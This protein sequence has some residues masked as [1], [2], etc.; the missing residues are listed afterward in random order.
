MTMRRAILL[1]LA[2]SILGILG[3]V[4]AARAQ[5]GGGR[6]A[7]VVRFP[8]GSVE[9]RCV[10]F[11]GSSITGAEL[12]A[13]SGLQIILDYNSGLGGAVCSIAGSG[14][15]FPAQECFCQC[16]GLSCEYWAYYHWRAGGWE[17][18]QVGASSFAVSDGAVEGWSWG[19]GNWFSG[20]EPP[21]LAFDQVC[22][23]PTSTPTATATPAPTATPTMTSAPVRTSAPQVTFRAATT[24]LATGAC[25]LL[26][27]LVWDADRVT[28]DGAPVNGQDR[29]EVCPTTTH[30]YV[31]VAINA[32]G[33]AQ[34]EITVQVAGSQPAQE[35]PPTPAA[36]IPISA[37]PSVPEP[38]ATSA[39]DTPDHSS[40]SILVPVVRALDQPAQPVETPFVRATQPPRSAIAP[41]FLGPLPTAT[42]RPRRVLGAGGRPTPTP[43]L[44]AMA[45]AR[46]RAGVA[47][48]AQ[49]SSTAQGASQSGPAAISRE[50]TP[51]LL[52]GYA[53][54]LVMAA[55]LL[56]AGAWVMLRKRR[57]SAVPC[58]QP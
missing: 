18:S 29:L 50:F 5:D 24:S 57:A 27:W 11:S 58:K 44:V 42:P 32:A 9:T 51:A 28:L 6:A 2:S 8:D 45:P 40:G 47:T 35:L 3:G 43:M 25:T 23:A 15:A 55:A 13:R 54:Y 34:R 39:T 46:S 20:V 10:G 1:A 33:E 37:S 26:D 12:L 16:Q 30:R 52:P 4:S 48:A 14:C 49:R 22:V 41:A 56:S 19:P 38:A 7:L 17:Y 53:A 36:E 31:L 21:V